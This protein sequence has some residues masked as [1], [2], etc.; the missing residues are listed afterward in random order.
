MRQLQPVSG[1]NVVV[2]RSCSTNR[3]R[4][5]NRLVTKET[6]SHANLEGSYYY[7]IIYL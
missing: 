6:Y 3:L 1:H 7:K 5:P 2:F 4:A